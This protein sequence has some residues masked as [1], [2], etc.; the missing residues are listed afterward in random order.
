[1]EGSLLP[2]QCTTNNRQLE[3]GTAADTRDSGLSVA[4]L[5]ARVAAAA[6]V[7]AGAVVAGSQGAFLRAVDEHPDAVLLRVD[8]LEHVR[9]VAWVVASTASWS[10]LTAR[11]TW[12]VLMQRT[13]LSRASV[14]RWLRWL[15]ERGLL[16]IVE[17]GTTPRFAPMALA[18]DAANRAALYVLCVPAPPAAA[19]ESAVVEG[20]FGIASSAP[21]E[22]S[23]TP[24]QLLLRSGR[25]PYAGARGT[26]AGAV[27]ALLVAH[28][29]RS[30]KRGEP[31]WPRG[32]V[33][34]SRA[35]RLTLVETLQASAPTLRLASARALRSELRPWLER[36]ELGW[37]V[38][39]LLHALDHT[40]DGRPHPYTAAV[41]V[42][43]RWLAHRMSLWLDEYGRP[44]PAPGVQHAADRSAQR[45]ETAAAAAE[46]RGLAGQR[47]GEQDF[48][49]LVRDVAGA[50][51]PD[52]LA[53]VLKRDLPGAGQ[54]L[55]P[56][57]AAEAIT[58]EAVR[59][60][61]KDTEA[62]NS[63]TD[64]RNAVTTAVS[65]LLSDGSVT[66]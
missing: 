8:A 15:R 52:L 4:E 18:A 63:T 51:Y 58:R 23:E 21:V 30:D 2:T 29:E 27:G 16:G 40:P 61:M 50:R 12:P 32:A 60:L 54:K 59:A 19:V 26:A 39:W 14:A 1:M 47:E 17:S 33:A 24:T 38:R 55:V 13:G 53:A 20:S 42:P 46:R 22:E 37:T 36:P 41:R 28:Q 25:N 66:P 64:C 6:V 31:R 57:A 35:D 44:L 3:A 11:P 62:R 56:A 49:E 65:Q 9:A 45:A 10:T 43:V 7:P 5:A 34:G 48:A